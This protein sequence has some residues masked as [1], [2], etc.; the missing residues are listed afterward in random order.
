[1]GTIVNIAKENKRTFGFRNFE[2]LNTTN[3]N[4]GTQ[5]TLKWINGV[6]HINIIFF[7]LFL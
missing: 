4:I 5:N 7:L 6:K 1:V 2:N 3:T